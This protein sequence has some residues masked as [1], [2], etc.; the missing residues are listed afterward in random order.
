M[1][2]RNLIA[3]A[4]AAVLL[5]ACI[6]SVNPFYTNKDVV[7]DPRLLGEWQMKES[8]D[9]P[10]LWKFEKGDDKA[11]KLTVTEKDSKRGEF[12]AH[13]FKL[14]QEFFLDL[15]PG[16][17]DY[18]TNQADLVAFSMFPGHLLLRVPQLGPEL[19]LAFCDFDWLKK[20]LEANP[21][22]LA[23]RIEQDRILLTASTRDLQRFVLRH[24]AAGEL[25]Q[26]PGE[27]VRKEN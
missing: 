23:H 27:L 6:P 18:A 5:S 16:N 14:K 15:I 12:N 22:A 11:Y 4:I 19:K 20:H 3:I 7:F 1:K 26:K 25:F 21:K 10:Q 24:L 9:E 13:L 8:S 17:C 2:T